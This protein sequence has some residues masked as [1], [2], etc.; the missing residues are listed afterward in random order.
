MFPLKGWIYLFTSYI[1]SEIIYIITYN[2]LITS[3]EILIEGNFVQGNYDVE[4][5]WTDGKEIAVYSIQIE[6]IS[7]SNAFP[8]EILLLIGIMA[9]LAI[10][11]VPSARK[12]IKQRN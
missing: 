10:I 12:Y 2:E 7:L 1:L 8:I 11:V 9:G 4:I 5:F 6:V 3:L